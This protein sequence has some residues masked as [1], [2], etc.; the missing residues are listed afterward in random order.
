MPVSILPLELIQSHSPSLYVPYN[1]HLQ[2]LGDVRYRV[3]QVRRCA[4]W[5][6]NV[7]QKQA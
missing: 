4:A 1:K 7:E 5:L 6:T 3:N 2:I